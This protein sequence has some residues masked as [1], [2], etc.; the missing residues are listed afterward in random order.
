MK[1][2]ILI[3]FLFAFIAVP[4]LAQQI[5]IEEQISEEELIKFAKVEIMT[6]DFVENKNKDLKEMIV[7]NKQLG[8][9]ARFNQIKAAWGDETKMTAITLTPDEKNAYQQTL[10][11]MSEMRQSVLEYKTGLIKDDSILGIATYNKINNA[12]KIDPT[13]KE[14]LNIL[15]GSLRAKVKSNS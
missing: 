3:G 7:S 6:A 11:F 15:I 14:K 8:G 5:E 13:L 10:D 1:K 9:G 4:T 12:I 2:L